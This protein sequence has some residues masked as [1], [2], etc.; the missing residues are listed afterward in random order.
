VPYSRSEKTADGKTRTINESIPGGFIFPNSQTISNNFIVLTD[1]GK[2]EFKVR[3]QNFT[4]LTNNP[5]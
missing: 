3:I 5:N 1:K 2:P 4:D